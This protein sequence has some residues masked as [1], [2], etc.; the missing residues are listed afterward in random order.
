MPT[1]QSA[2]R[3]FHSTETAVIKVHNDLLLAADNRDVSTLCLLDLSID[4]ILSSTAGDYMNRLSNCCP[5]SNVGTASSIKCCPKN[6]F[7]M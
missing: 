6:R 7:V 5:H 2:Y 1:M 4:Y 3:Q